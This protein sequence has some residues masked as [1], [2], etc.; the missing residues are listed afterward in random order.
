MP[1]AVNKIEFGGKQLNE[2]LI[3][4]RIEL[5]SRKIF[6]DPRT[7]KINIYNIFQQKV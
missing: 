5:R 3:K 7:V 4:L 6:E 1:H 2:Y